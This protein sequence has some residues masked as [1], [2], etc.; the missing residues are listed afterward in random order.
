MEQQKQ[1]FIK[2]HKKKFITFGTILAI[3]SLRWLLSR[4]E[5]QLQHDYDEDYPHELP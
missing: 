5:S 1:N 2:K 4:R 3:T